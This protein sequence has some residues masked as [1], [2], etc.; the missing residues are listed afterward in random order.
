MI[1]LVSACVGFPSDIKDLVRK[2]RELWADRLGLQFNYYTSQMTPFGWHMNWTKVPCIIAELKKGNQ[3]L[4]IDADA[5]IVTKPDLTDLH[6]PMSVA[7]DNNGW[8]LGVWYICPEMLW[9]PECMMMQDQYKDGHP[10]ADQCPFNDLDKAG[11]LHNITVLDASKWNS[12]VHTESEYIRHWAG[13]Y[14]TRWD[15]MRK[16][17]KEIV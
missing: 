9:V 15:E 16:L 11:L 13:Q 14:Q 4:W 2:N 12:Y 17:S 1:T 8:N 7:K 3:V 5:L 10:F 6:G